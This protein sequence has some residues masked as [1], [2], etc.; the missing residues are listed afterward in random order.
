MPNINRQIQ[1][2]HAVP[3]W[4]RPT[5][6]GKQTAHNVLFWKFLN[7]FV[8][9]NLY[10]IGFKEVRGGALSYNHYIQQS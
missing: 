6:L 3:D 7:V 1:G 9:R 2:S 10:L 4:D 5:I 8:S